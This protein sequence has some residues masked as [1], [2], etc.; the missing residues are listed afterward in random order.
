MRLALVLFLAALA[1]QAQPRRIVSTTP[2][3]TEML[4]ALG[5]GD[6]VVGVTTFCRYPEQARR[7]AK[8][9]TYTEPNYEAILSLRPD[10]VLIQE[11]PIG[12]AAKLQAMGLRVLELKHTSVGDIFDSIAKIGEAMGTVQRATGLAQ[13]IRL[14][15]EAVRRRTADL[16]Q[17][18][19]LFVIGRTPNALEGLVA[20]GKASYLNELMAVAGGRSVFD[21]AVPAY[22]R[23][24]F[25]EILA[26]DPDVIID[27]GEM[28]N[29]QGVTE[30][31]KARVLKLWSRYPGLSAVK[32]KRLHA[33]ASDIYVVP[34][35]RMV[36]A[37][38]EFARMLHPE[39]G[40]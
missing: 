3:I 27:M 25:E 26:R 24:S 38:R 18:R 5:V 37:A 8:I 30:A 29:T 40:I 7:L 10:L 34:G 19:L 21:D 9:G 16:P 6:R 11:N 4:F 20:V 32:N 31:D 23:V 39:A 33:V 2:S 35:T 1:G 22:P 15:L 36:E 13:T 12:M 17:R 28:A 14:Q